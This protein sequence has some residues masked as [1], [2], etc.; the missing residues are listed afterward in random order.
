MSGLSLL[1]FILFFRDTF[2]RERSLNYQNALKQR[3]KATALESLGGKQPARV[4]E[5]IEKNT[6]KRDSTEPPQETSLPAVSLAD[7]NPL[8]PIGQVLRRKN[9]IIILIS[10]GNDFP[11][12]SY[13]WRDPL[14]NLCTG[15]QFGFNTL[16]TYACA[17]TLSASYGY[18]PLKIGLVTLSFGIGKFFFFFFLNFKQKS[19]RLWHFGV[20][21]VSLVVC[22][23]AAGLIMSLHV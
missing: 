2:R 10:S 1:S 8:K 13:F 15:I 23:V 9:N 5:S 20:Q 19:Y 21:E 4:D 12:P 17:R 14:T 7:I 18:S 16:I 11:P 3:C 22:W 6:L